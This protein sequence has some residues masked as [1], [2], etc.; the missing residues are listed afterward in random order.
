MMI[1][2][3]TTQ[4]PFATAILVVLLGVTALAFVLRCVLVVAL[5][6]ARMPR[7]EAWVRAQWTWFPLVGVVGGLAAYLGPLRGSGFV[8]I[9]VG[10]VFLMAR[11]SG[12]GRRTGGT[13]TSAPPSS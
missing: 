5:H 11:R 9:A 13:A 8:V 4:A 7:A 6:A 10:L 2:I 3:A 12:L 1:A